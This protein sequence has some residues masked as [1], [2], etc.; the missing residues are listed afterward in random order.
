MCVRLAHV[1]NAYKARGYF[2]R[3]LHTCVDGAGVLG[4][5]VPCAGVIG[6]VVLV[7]WL[8]GPCVLGVVCVAQVSL[9]LVQYACT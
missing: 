1:P 3:V 4:A 8:V 5:G 2:V 9:V 6:A 7:T